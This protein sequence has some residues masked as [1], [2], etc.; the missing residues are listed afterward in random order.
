[1]FR[2]GLSIYLALVTL[3]G[4]WLCCCTA[5]RA[6][7]GLLRSPAG[8]PEQPKDDRPACCCHHD[9]QRPTQPA[10]ERPARENSGRR[11]CPCGRDPNRVVF[12]LDAESA[13]HLQPAPVAPKPVDLLAVPVTCFTTP[14]DCL[15]P[16]PRE[17]RG[18]PFLTASDLLRLLHVL[19]C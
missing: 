7:A 18:L 6:T 4:P 2:V 17:R 13:R 15:A 9:A 8:Q 11:D 14:A 19:R 5:A 16:V 12:A 3:A 1:M 10:P